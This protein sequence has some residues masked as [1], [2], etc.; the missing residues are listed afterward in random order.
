M[1]TIG[2]RGGGAMPLPTT[3]SPMQQGPCEPGQSP[4]QS[5]VPTPPPMQSPQW[6]QGPT[7]PPPKVPQGPPGSTT[8]PPGFPPPT[9]QPPSKPTP[10]PGKPTEPTTP[11]GPPT[12]PEPPAKGD[13]F[14]LKPW[15]IGAGVVAA[16]VGGFFAIRAGVRN[17]QALKATE[18][19]FAAGTMHQGGLQAINDAKLGATFANGIGLGDYAKVAVPGVNRIGSAG[20][21][22][23]VARGHLDHAELMA[24]ATALQRLSGDAVSVSKPLRSQVLGELKD[25]RSLPAVLGELNRSGAGAKPVFSNPRLAGYWEQASIVE[26]GAKLHGRQISSALS[27]DRP[28]LAL[29]GRQI[30]AAEGTSRIDQLIAARGARLGARDLANGVGSIQAANVGT[31]SPPLRANALAMSKVDPALVDAIGLPGAFTQRWQ[32]RLAMAAAA[33]G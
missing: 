22:T 9:N 33:A 20:R 14:N 13:G 31:L 4:V 29:E 15:L 25:G 12:T 7:S 16:G 30:I 17:I 10:P 18:A 32:D 5:P 24:S 6:P 21:L 8:P 27:V 23:S 2:I 26:S 28:A 1:S 11:P 3:Q 19:S